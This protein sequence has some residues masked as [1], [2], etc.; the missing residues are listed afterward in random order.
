MLDASVVLATLFGEPCATTGSELMPV[1][2]LLS[3]NLA[4]IVG[5]L[6]DAGV[7]AFDRRA[8]IGRL[9]C[10]IVPFDATL[11]RVADD[12]RERTTRLS[13]GDRA[14]LALAMVRDLPVYTAD[15]SWAE[16]SLPVEVRLIR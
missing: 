5:K 1:G 10:E 15:R 11:A 9:G 13:L 3:V 14:C 12:L 8:V 6:V 4:E 2:A 16:L 7:P